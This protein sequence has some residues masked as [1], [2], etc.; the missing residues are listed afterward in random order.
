MSYLDKMMGDNERPVF[1]THQHW[2]AFLLTSGMTVALLFLAI[3][4]TVVLFVYVS[5]QLVANGVLKDEFTRNLVLAIVGFIILVYPLGHF[6]FD[7]FWWKSEYYIVTNFRVIRLTGIF[8]KSVQDSSLEKVNDIVM[9]QSLIGRWLGYGFLEIVTG[10]DIGVNKFDRVANPIEFKT[11]M[12][13]AKHLLERSMYPAYPQMAQPAVGSTPAGQTA[14]PANG[15][16]MAEQI[17]QLAELRDQGILTEEEFQQGK[18]K[19]LGA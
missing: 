7:F 4:F 8:N 10:S 18:Q 13:D 14:A 19:L 16:S 6:L 15:P 1:S 9:R 11:A 17:A 12:L 3:L 2:I 5:P